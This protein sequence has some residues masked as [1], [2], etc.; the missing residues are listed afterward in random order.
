MS[1]FDCVSLNRRFAS[2]LTMENQLYT[3]GFEHD[4]TESTDAS[5]TSTAAN[6]VTFYNLAVK[7][8]ATYVSDI[9]GN[10]RTLNFV[11]I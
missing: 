8:M 2:W 4:Y 10:V 3:S 9:S 7:K 11:I 6:G 1:D 5:Q